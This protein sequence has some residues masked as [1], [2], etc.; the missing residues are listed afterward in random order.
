MG[1]ESGPARYI[2]ITHDHTKRP[3]MQ[4]ISLPAGANINVLHTL[5]LPAAVCLSGE[6]VEGPA[7]ALDHNVSNLAELEALCDSLAARPA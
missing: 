3:D 4:T 1:V 7:P 2:P 6:S 5:T